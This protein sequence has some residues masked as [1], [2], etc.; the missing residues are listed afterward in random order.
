[1]R[2]DATRY[3][4]VTTLLHW[5]IGLVLLGQIAF[6]FLLDDIAP[7]GTPSRSAVINLHKSFGIVLGLLIVARLAWR[8]AHRPPAWPA[9]MPH[10]QQRAALWAHRALYA[11]MVAMP[12]SG[13][14]ASNFSKHGVKFFGVLL[15]PWGPDVPAVYEVFN[16]VHVVTAFVFVS[17]IAVHVGAALKHAWVDR[18]G[19]F[20]RIWPRLGPPPQPSPSG[21]GGATASP[22]GQR[23]ASPSAS[24]GRSGWGPAA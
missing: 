21:G 5:L 12:L 19:V 11:C 7:R 8:L 1:M 13:Y 2:D 4:T 14:V 20:S 17:L 18:D 6:G 15:K 22:A 10:W 23:S 24:G 3:D 9:G 16:G